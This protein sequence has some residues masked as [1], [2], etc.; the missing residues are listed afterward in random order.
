MEIVYD[1]IRMTPAEIVAS[2]ADSGAHV[3]GVSILSGSHLALLE[4]VIARMSADG[5]SHIPVVAG[6]I[7]PEDDAARL[8]SMGIARVYSPKD[9]QLNL[10]M[11]D[12][13]EL[14]DPGDVAAQ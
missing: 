5:L 10:I 2:L 9:F 11:A 4:D 14:A 12:I 1:G 8:R 6:G 7:I 3:L 13:V